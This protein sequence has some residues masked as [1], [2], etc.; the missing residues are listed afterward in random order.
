MKSDIFFPVPIIFLKKV[1][2]STLIDLALVVV[3]MV[4]RLLDLGDIVEAKDEHNSVIVCVNSFEKS[5]SWLNEPE[6]HEV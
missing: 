6:N 2:I 1:F 4:E 3:S 5:I